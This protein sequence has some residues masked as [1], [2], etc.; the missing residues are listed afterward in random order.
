VTGSLIDVHIHLLP[1]AIIRAYRSRSAPPLMEEDGPSL[2]LRFGSSYAER[3]PR[4]VT[5]LRHVLATMDANSVDAAVLSINQPGVI[6]LP[7][8]EA[9]STARAANDE[10]ADL[11]AGSRG[12][13]TGLAT[14][15]WQCPADAAD[16]LHRAVGIG[17]RGAM[18]CSNVGGRSLD[19][20]DFA[21]VFAA[22]A[23]RDVPLLLHPALPLSAPTL[24]GYGLTCAVGFLFDT[25]TAVL[26]LVLNGLFD[27]HPQIKLVLCH[28]GSLLPQ[29]AGRL[30]LEQQRGMLAGSHL[31]QERLSADYLRLLYTDT[32]GGSPAA[33]SS[34][35]K[36]FGPGHVMFGS[37]APFWSQAVGL[38]ILEQLALP[39]E[40]LADIRAR[41]AT[42]LFGLRR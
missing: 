33:V 41:T 5:D 9:I 34:A 32:A 37:D 11:A 23:D 6:G 27:R 42:E 20:P 13:I 18:A 17:L 14:L 3:I 35:L 15:P 10:L 19:H 4:E 30:D 21:P 8:A 28:A 29:L 24:G 16:E 12:R 38:R 31:R 1:A 26:R 7:P 2:V 25:T 39:A 22:A 40:Q 36:L